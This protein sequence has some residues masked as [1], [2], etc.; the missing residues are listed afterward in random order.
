MKIWIQNSVPLWGLSRRHVKGDIVP[1]GVWVRFCP[2]F[3]KRHLTAKHTHTPGRM[4]C[5]LWEGLRCSI[6]FFYQ[7][8]NIAR[9]VFARHSTETASIWKVVV[10]GGSSALKFSPERHEK[11]NINVPVR[12]IWIESE[13][14]GRGFKHT[15][16][17]GHSQTLFYC[18]TKSLYNRF[19]VTIN[20]A[21]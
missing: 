16:H 3:Q 20:A 21:R 15:N 5:H 6:V 9:S 18:Q 13:Q 11:Q 7:I 12:I 17:T 4:I 14:Q 10:G 8:I 1:P 19:F 2:V